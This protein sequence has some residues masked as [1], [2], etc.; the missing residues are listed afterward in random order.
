MSDTL[1]ESEDQMMMDHDCIDIDNNPTGKDCA[2]CR[3]E[4]HKG[5]TTT[6]QVTK[7][8]TCVIPGCPV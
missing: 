2:A 1:Q 7:S 3:A 4:R 5:Q 6:H 8:G